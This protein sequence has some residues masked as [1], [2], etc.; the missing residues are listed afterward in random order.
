MPT[1]RSGPQPGAQVAPGEGGQGP[2]GSLCSRALRRYARRV[3]A[4]PCGSARPERR[5]MDAGAG[6]AG[7]RGLGDWGR[8][9]GWRLSAEEGRSVCTRPHPELVRALQVMS[10]QGRGVSAA[11]I[12]ELAEAWLAG[13]SCPVSTRGLA[14]PGLKLS[15]A[16]SLS[17][18][19]GGNSSPGSSI[20]RAAFTGFNYWPPV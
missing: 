9:A 10:D 7:G 6:G 11:G 15:P 20:Q 5:R 3:P 13:G 19:W 1:W 16:S 12:L 4:P 18:A 2:R 14:W 17:T 8:E